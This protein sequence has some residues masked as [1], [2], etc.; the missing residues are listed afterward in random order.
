MLPPA[1]PLNGKHYIGLSDTDVL[2]L[3][4]F[5]AL[6]EIINDRSI[7]FVTYKANYLI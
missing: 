1:I 3:H 7:P 4:I 5:Y 6:H 2:S